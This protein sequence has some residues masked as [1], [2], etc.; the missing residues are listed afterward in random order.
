[1]PANSTTRTAM[2]EP[3]PMLI[4]F[5]RLID[6]KVK[7]IDCPPTLPHSPSST[8]QTQSRRIAVAGDSQ[9]KKPDGK[10]R[11]FWENP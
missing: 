8:G 1:L 4:L 5:Y 2:T 10:G 7:I 9:G 6:V 11:F 3:L